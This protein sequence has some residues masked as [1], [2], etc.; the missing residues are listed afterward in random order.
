MLQGLPVPQELLVQLV[1]LDRLEPMVLPDQQEQLELLAQQVRMEQ[2]EH[3][4]QLVP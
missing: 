3:K 1:V 4:D 2:L